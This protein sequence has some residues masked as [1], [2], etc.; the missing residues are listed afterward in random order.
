MN[1]ILHSIINLFCPMQ[2]LI[3]QKVVCGRRENVIGPECISSI[4]MVKSL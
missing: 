3:V 2:C 1:C 4:Q